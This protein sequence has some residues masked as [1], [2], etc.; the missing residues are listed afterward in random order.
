VRI[1]ILKNSCISYLM[2]LEK[3][4]K[5]LFEEW[6]PN[7]ILTEREVN[8]LIFAFIVTILSLC[9]KFYKLS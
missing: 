1:Y 3:F 2:I 9:K 8:L 7:T 5:P 4:M 6:F